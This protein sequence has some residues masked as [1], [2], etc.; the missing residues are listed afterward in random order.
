MSLY[1]LLLSYKQ[2]LWKIRLEA[3]IETHGSSPK[4]SFME[5]LQTVLKHVKKP[6][7]GTERNRVLYKKKLKNP[8]HG[9]FM[10][11]FSTSYLNFWIPASRNHMEASV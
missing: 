9:A 4:I 8:L 6:V 7:K 3:V 2:P 10:E 1:K 5:P 11:I